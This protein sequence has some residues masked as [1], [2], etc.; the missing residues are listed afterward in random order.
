MNYRNDGKIKLKI[1]LW[2]NF[3]IVNCNIFNNK[4]NILHLFVNIVFIYTKLKMITEIMYYG[5]N[6]I[7][8]PT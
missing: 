1:N 3:G 2:E 8:C 4:E 6:Y 7:L 5:S